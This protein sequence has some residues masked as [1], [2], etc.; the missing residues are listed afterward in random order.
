VSAFGH[1]RGSSQLGRALA[2]AGV[3]I[4]ALALSVGPWSR[5]LLLLASARGCKGPWEV[6]W[7]GRRP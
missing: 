2:G 1:S 7:E 3:L 5:E 6:A 4:P